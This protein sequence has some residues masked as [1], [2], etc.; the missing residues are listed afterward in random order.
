MESPDPQP[1]ND[2]T[3]EFFHTLSTAK[4]TAAPEPTKPLSPRLVG[5]VLGALLGL[6]YGI[7]SQLVNQLLLPGV[8]FAQHPFG[9]V[10]NCLFS[11]ASGALIGLVST[12]PRSAVN[13]VF[14]GS[15]VAGVVALLQ[16]L[17]AHAAQP[18]I[19]S[20]VLTPTPWSPF[21]IV[22]YLLLFV[23]FMILF[24]LT[25]DNQVE[26][27]HK[28]I[29]SWKR[30]RGPLLLVVIIGVVGG[31]SLFPNHV[32]QALKD[33]HT[34]IQTGLVVS[35][36][37]DLPLDLRAEHD[38]TGFMDY[39]SPDYTLESS[40]DFGLKADLTD[41][42]MIYSLVIIAR[43]KSH[44]ILACAYDVTGNR[45]H[46]RSYVTPEFYQRMGFLIDHTNPP[47]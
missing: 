2:H 32:Q 1:T 23:P 30:I 36:M 19:T 22:F 3:T 35:D 40:D 21:Q 24:R 27:A 43:F 16:W 33:M 17:A 34:L 15:I 18:S 29:W 8:P 46:C 11:V 44:W 4:Q 9:L 37:A 45:S 42:D 20:T 28:P 7:I 31:F 6:V 39:A 38:V 25:V 12:L 47:G 10:G 41:P 14:V 26:W 13:G 5:L